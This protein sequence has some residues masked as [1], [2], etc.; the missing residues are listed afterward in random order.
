RL[1]TD[2][3][4]IGQLLHARMSTRHIGLAA[5]T[6]WLA[7]AIGQAR[8][9]GEDEQSRRLETDADAVQVL[10][11]HR[12]KGLEFGVVLLPEAWDKRVPKDTGQVLAFHRTDPG[13]GRAGELVLD[14]GGVTAGGR[15]DRHEQ[16]RAEAAGEDLRQLYVAL[17]RARHQVITW[18]APSWN[19]NT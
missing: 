9:S 17:T 11:V 10:T 19:T 8:R 13:T 6:D 12:A 18:W 15:A 14:V 2:L 1:V 4:H 5:V 16:W 7:E 3:R